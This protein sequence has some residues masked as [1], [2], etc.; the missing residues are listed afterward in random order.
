MQPTFKTKSRFQPLAAAILF[1]VSFMFAVFAVTTPDFNASDAT[2]LAF[3][4]NRSNRITEIVAVYASLVAGG[5]LVWF[6]AQLAERV[7][8]PVIYAAGWASAVMLWVSSVLFSA[9]P[10]AMSISGAPPPSAELDRLAADMG[11]A[12]LTWFAVP[13]AAFLIAAACFSG[14]RTG[15]L[16]RWVCWLGFVVA[17]VVGVGGIAFIPLPLLVL[18][19]LLAGASLTFGRERGPATVAAPA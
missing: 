3:W 1:A 10:A 17:V 18:W 7:A 4:N 19:V 12:A 8:N 11:A 6:A 14:L 9:A 15:A 13:I 16:R 2:W 5:A